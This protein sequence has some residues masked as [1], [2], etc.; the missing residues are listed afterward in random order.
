MYSFIYFLI[1]TYFLVLSNVKVANSH[2]IQRSCLWSAEVP[3]GYWQIAR[4]LEVC[5]SH[6]V[7]A[8]FSWCP[9]RTT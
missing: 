7:L 8:C 6:S 2:G 1:Y 4:A 9:D 5:R 3:V